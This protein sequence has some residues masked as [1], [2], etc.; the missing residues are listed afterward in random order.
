[1]FMNINKMVRQTLTK[2]LGGVAMAT[3]LV[4]CT[5]SVDYSVDSNTTTAAN[6]SGY[7]QNIE[8][9]RERLE[10]PN[11]TATLQDF[12]IALGPERLIPER[13]KDL[14]RLFN[15]K[16][17]LDI[18]DREGFVAVY[19]N[20][21]KFKAKM[22]ASARD[23]YDNLDLSKSEVKEH[24]ENW[25]WKLNSADE[26]DKFILFIMDSVKKNKWYGTKVF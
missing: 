6:V 24:N 2:I 18:S 10:S 14:K 12:K 16:D 17:E 3:A 23:A 13:E 15:S 26:S 22:S 9:L 7:S 8:D 25:M 19:V 11:Y 21:E 4:G 20:R 5:P 1:M